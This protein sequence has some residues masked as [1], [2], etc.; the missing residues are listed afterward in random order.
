M[1][2]NSPEELYD[3]VSQTEYGWLY[4]DG[5]K[6]YKLEMEKYQEKYILQTPEEVEK[7]KIGICWDQVE[8]ERKLFELDYETQSY[9]I[10]NHLMA[11]SFLILHKEDDYIYFE[12]SSPQS[13]GIYHFSKEEEALEYA[14]QRFKENHHI[15]ADKKVDL[16]PYSPLEQG[17]TFQEIKDIVYYEKEKREGSHK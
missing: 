8:L 2:I 4:S 14:T 7:N 11:H 1:E 6:H 15:K 9:A 12:H 10:F 13:K 16:V 5:Q 17:T 3:L